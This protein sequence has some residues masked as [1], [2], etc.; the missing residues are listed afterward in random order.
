MG[1]PKELVD[2]RL[3]EEAARCLRSLPDGRIHLR[4]LAISKSAHYPIG[5]VASFFEVSRSTLT[6]WIRR[7]REGGIEG[8][9][10]RPK[11]H[12]IALLGQAELEVI[13][14]WLRESKDDA[15]NPKHWTLEELRQAIKRRFGIDITLMPLWRQVRALQFRQKI[16]RPAHADADPEAQQAFK[17]N[18]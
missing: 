4:L 6:Q 10:D 12:R 2:T 8:L 17:K 1:R 14:A 11:G 7:F 9:S 3:A 16:P 5:E 13:G 18:G 15:G